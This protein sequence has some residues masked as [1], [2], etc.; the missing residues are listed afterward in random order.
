LRK[1]G[2]DRRADKPLEIIAGDDD[3]DVFHDAPLLKPSEY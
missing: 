3:A 1:R 2:F